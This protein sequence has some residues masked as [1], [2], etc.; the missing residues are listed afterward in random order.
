MQ[1]YNEG[2]NYSL[3]IKLKLMPVASSLFEIT[4]KVIES[5]DNLSNIFGGISSAS[6]RCRNL[7]GA[8]SLWEEYLLEGRKNIQSVKSDNLLK[9]KF[10]KL[11]DNT[12]SEI[13]KIKTFLNIESLSIGGNY[14]KE[15]RGNAYLE[16]KDLLIFKEKKAEKLRK[17]GF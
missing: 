16:N 9:L 11:L 15:D 8:F 12:D 4:N 6:L 7:E 13:E 10:E 3:T 1:N 17:Y 14:I 5:T 2:K